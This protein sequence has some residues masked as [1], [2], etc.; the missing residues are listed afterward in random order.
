M[1]AAYG[2]PLRRT[3][4]SQWNFAIGG[5]AIIISICIVSVSCGWFGI[6][7]A[8]IKIEGEWLAIVGGNDPCSR[9]L[10]AEFR[11][12]DGQPLVCCNWREKSRSTANLN[13][14]ES[15]RDTHLTLSFFEK[16]KNTAPIDLKQLPLILQARLARSISV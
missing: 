15:C 7:G 10:N 11:R 9:E 13:R 12:D 1:Y 2:K 3:N 5:V 6:I 4:V 8:M 16:A 14:G